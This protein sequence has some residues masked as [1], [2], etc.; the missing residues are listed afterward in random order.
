[1]STLELAANRST[2][3]QL[4]E[5]LSACDASFT[6]PLSRRVAIGDYAA[7]LAARAHRCE[8]WA[9]NQLVG[10]VAIYLND[11]TGYI[12]NVSV[13]PAWHGHRIASTLLAEALTAARTAGLRRVDLEVD[14]ANAP[15]IA[16]YR[17]AG[18][19]PDAAARW[20]KQ[21]EGL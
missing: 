2:D 1:M 16:L 12:S 11:D 20:T 3:A 6:P 14:P 5:H 15:A 7:K 18:F 21:L 13:L 10:V 8:A 17:A 19:A 4:G 9:G